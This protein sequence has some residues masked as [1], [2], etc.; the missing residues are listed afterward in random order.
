MKMVALVWLSASS[1]PERNRKRSAG[2]ARLR[3]Q[4]ES[5]IRAISRA[6]SATGHSHESL[7]SQNHAVRLRNLIIAL[8]L[9]GSP[10]ASPV[11]KLNLGSHKILTNDKLSVLISTYSI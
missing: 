7:P 8:S 2:P 5:R 4:I 1:P 3:R 6:V 11:P 10:D 9:R